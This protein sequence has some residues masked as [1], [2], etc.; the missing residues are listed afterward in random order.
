LGDRLQNGSPYAIGPLSVLTYP[1][2]LSVTLVCCGQTVE[3]IKI[4]LGMQV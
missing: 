1:V 4:K 3:W 2:C